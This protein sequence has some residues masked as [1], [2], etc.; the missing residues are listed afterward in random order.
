[1]VLGKPYEFRMIIHKKI[2]HMRTKNIALIIIALAFNFLTAQ[3]QLRIEYELV[4]PEENFNTPDLSNS[5]EI[6]IPKLYFELILNQDESIWKSIERIDNEQNEEKEGGRV[7]FATFGAFYKNV[8]EKIKVREEESYS[9]NYLIKDSLSAFN[10]KITKENKEILK[11]QVQKAIFSDEES[12]IE[13]IAWYAPKLNFKHGPD[14]FWGLPGLILE[15]E[16]ITYFDDNTKSSQTYIARNVETI[17]SNK[18]IEQPK[19]GIV[20]T[21]IELNKIQKDNFDKMMKMREQGVDKD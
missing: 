8:K 20:V 15:I 17:K 18:K 5:I 9:K 2:K 7:S 19:K 16:V 14:E 10:W 11:I 21:Q 3:E 1:M 6:K 13:L 4:V 12:G